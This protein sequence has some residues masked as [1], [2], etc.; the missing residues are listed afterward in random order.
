M[1]FV[2]LGFVILASTGIFFLGACSHSDQAGNSASNPAPSQTVTK[3]ETSA[4][5]EALHGG[6]VVESG[7]YHLEFVPEKA[8]KG[9]HMDLFL[10]K[11]DKHQAV[12]NAKVTAQV[13]T[14]DSNQKTLNMTYD[15]ADKHYTTL[16]PVTT[17]GQYQVKIVA[18]VAGKKIDGRFSFNK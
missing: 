11:G 1:K 12:P 7:A 3:A 9:T 16:L 5:T 2:K 6:Q 4:S 13:Q 14:P 18:V 10:L 8:E 15:Q 17:P